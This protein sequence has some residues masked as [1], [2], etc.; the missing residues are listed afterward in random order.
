VQYAAVGELAAF[1]INLNSRYQ[2]PHHAII[3]SID[4]GESDVKADLAVGQDTV[5][6]LHML[7]RRRGWL[8]MPRIVVKSYYPF[9]FICVWSYVELEHRALI[10]PQPIATDLPPLGLG[11]GDEGIRLSMQTGDEFQGF[12]IYQPG[13]PLSQIAWKQY[14]RGAG[15]HL[16]DYRALQSKHYWLDFQMMDSRDTELALSQLT[17]WVIQFSADN[18]EFGLLLPGERLEL[19]SGDVHRLNALT[20]LALVGWTR[21]ESK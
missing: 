2:S 1:E 12:Q 14:A 3:L 13:A 18:C 8:K 20:A 15:L 6:R 4:E 9:G 17:Y 19:G 11:E 16:K 10:F 7:A 21:E 5:I